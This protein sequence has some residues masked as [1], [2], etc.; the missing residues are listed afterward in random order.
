MTTRKKFRGG[1]PLGD[2]AWRTRAACAG[3]DTD[4]FYGDPRRQAAL[5]RAVCGPCPVRVPCLAAVLVF[6]AHAIG[7]RHGTAGGLSAQQRED[8][9]AA[10]LGVALVAQA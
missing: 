2:N 10:G 1:F 4:A 9:V 7:G 5:A 8:A 6:E 3:M